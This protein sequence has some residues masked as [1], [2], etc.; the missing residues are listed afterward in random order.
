[1][2]KIGIPRERT[3]SL[4]SSKNARY[5]LGRSVTGVAVN[6]AGTGSSGSTDR[7]ALQR[8]ARL[9]A[10]DSTRRRANQAAGDGSALGV[11]PC[12]IGT[13]GVG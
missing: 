6:R 4:K 11:G 7:R 1:M 2:T 5:R 9:M 3:T 12:G 8:T 13:V 10:Y